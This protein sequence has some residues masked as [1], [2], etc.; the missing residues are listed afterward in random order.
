VTVTYQ[1]TVTYTRKLI[2]VKKLILI[3]HSISKLD[4]DVSPHQ[5]GLTDEGRASCIPLAKQ[6]QAHEPEIVITSIEPK[7]IQTGEI[8]AQELGI[9]C[10]AADGLH[11]HERE[12]SKILGQEEWQKQIANLFAS[13]DTLI[14]GKETANQALVRFAGAVESILST[15]PH[16]KIA[17]VTHGTVM[18]LF[19]SQI[20]GRD[21]FKF[22]YKLGSPAFYVTSWPYY[23]V[24]SL[25]TQIE[26]F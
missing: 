25:A 21:A 22:W 3:R 26:T 4:P 11:E 13:P 10:W 5:W 24:T 1:V 8:I 7:A 16:K 23:I 18:S 20:A 19:Y 9:P 17:I 2:P 12:Q 15:Y 14:L 6:L